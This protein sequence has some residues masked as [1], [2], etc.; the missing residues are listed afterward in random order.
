MYNPDIKFTIFIDKRKEVG[1]LRPKSKLFANTPESDFY[2]NVPLFKKIKLTDEYV[3]IS[4][5]PT[6]HTIQRQL[7][8]PYFIEL[9]FFENI[10][11][12]SQIEEKSKKYNIKIN[13]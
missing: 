6:K 12:I 1:I 11:S 13:K 5:D 10:E 4:V 7:I 8:N 3:D 9:G 2:I